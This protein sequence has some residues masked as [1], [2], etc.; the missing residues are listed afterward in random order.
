MT[1]KTDKL[2]DSILNTKYESAIPAITLAEKFF[3]G[4]IDKIPNGMFWNENAEEWGNLPFDN[5]LFYLDTFVE[6]EI[7]PVILWCTQQGKEIIIHV[8]EQTNKGKFLF[9]GEMGLN[10]C[11]DDFVE[12]ITGAIKAHTALPE[13]IRNASQEVKDYVH[14]TLN[15]SLK[16]LANILQALACTNIHTKNNPAPDKINKK[17]LKNKKTPMFDF[18]TLHINMDDREQITNNEKTTSISNRSSPRAHFRRGHIR[19]IQ[20]GKRVF[21]Q[22][23]V[24]GD[25]NTGFIFK[26]YSIRAH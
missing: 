14:E 2:I 15:L 21:V 26:N 20:S 11:E 18:Y 5:C 8:F 13:D 22:P 1:T 24:V 17:R 10:F 4:E 6:D 7:T 12:P 25:K 23:C 9:D 16:W 3:I 19:R